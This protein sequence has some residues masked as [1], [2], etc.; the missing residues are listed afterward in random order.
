[1][2][3]ARPQDAGVTIFPCFRKM[4]TGVTHQTDIS[5][6][7]DFLSMTRTSTIWLNLRKLA[8]DPDGADICRLAA[9][10]NDIATANQFM[11][12]A[13]HEHLEGIFP[14]NTGLTV[15]FCCLTFA[16]CAECLKILGE[17]YADKPIE[18]PSRIRSILDSPAFREKEALLAVKPL[19]NEKHPD[20]AWFRDKLAFHYDKPQFKKAL[21][22]AAEAEDIAPITKGQHIRRTRF[23][24]ADLIKKRVILSGAKI[25]GFNAE[26]MSKGDEYMLRVGELS[27]NLLKIVE[28]LLIEFCYPL[29]K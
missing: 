5:S 16:H 1:M 9:A 4:D 25:P 3:R 22:E 2:P 10:W 29:A 12:L 24:V 14:N 26:T 23:R 27:H 15:Y 20:L 11:G 7:R 8:R 19:L 6:H 21:E 17:V 18:K 28:V 13:R